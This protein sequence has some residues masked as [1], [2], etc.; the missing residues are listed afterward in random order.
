MADAE[1]NP[2]SGA[3]VTGE[4]FLITVKDEGWNDRVD[5]YL[6]E[7]LGLL[8]RNQ[9]QKRC[10]TLTVNGT[11]AKPS[12]KVRCG[13]TVVVELGPEPLSELRAEAVPFS[14]IFENRDV[15]VLNKPRGLVVHPGAGNWSGTVAHGLLHHV[16][17][18]EGDPDELRPGIVHRLDK[19]TSGVL[20]CAKHQPAKEFLSSQFA[21]RTTEKRYLAVCKGIPRPLRGTVGGTIAR[22]PAQ[23]KRFRYLAQ[24]GKPAETSYRVI[25]VGEGYA[26]VLLEPRTGRTHQLRVHMAH[27]KAPILGDPVYA[28]R[29]PRFPDARLCLHALALKIVLPGESSSRTFTAVLPPDMRRIMS[30]LFH[31]RAGNQDWR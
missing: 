3:Q 2:P 6:T 11:P 14:I 29:D 13:D 9:L 26:L 21:Q 22:D 24:G 18:L 5:R 23:R 4:A 25:R 15:L 16:A 30:E 17:G 12:R 31:R 20:V 19:E 28:R 1:R 8:T 7:A 10:R 27:L